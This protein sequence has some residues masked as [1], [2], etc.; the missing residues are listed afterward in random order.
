MLTPPDLSPDVIA[1]Y[2]RDAY[3]VD[4]TQVTFLPIGAD[5][6]AAVYRLDAHG[7]AAYFLKL[8]RARFDE[9]AVAVPAFLHEHGAPAVM[10]PLLTA[11]GALWTS[12]H[13][14]AW[15]LYPFFDGPNGFL[16]PLSD[17]QWLTLG[18]SLR[19]VHS[20]ELPTSLAARIPREAYSP[21]WRDIVAAFSEQVEDG[22]FDD[23]I[24]ERLAAGWR[25]KRWE[26][27]TLVERAADLAQELQRRSLPFVLCHTDLHAGNVLLGAD[28][29]LAIVDWDDPI[30]APKE[31]DL[32]FF[33]AGVGA[34]WDTPREE[35]LFYQGYGPVEIDLTALAYYR[36]ERIVADFASY[37]EQIFEAQGSVEDR[38]N[39]VR[40]VMGQ[41]EP[42]RV[43][44]IAH[45]T[46]QRLP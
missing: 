5:A 30:L 1:A 13:G 35:T 36:Y 14:F 42:G 28:G 17:E 22:Y 19:A 45:R 3:S 37:G 44:D 26:I 43:I 2:V 24:A 7:G 18:K 16:R 38:E 39:G 40:K 4:V 23:P 20:A 29:E 9:I 41:F 11:G 25:E 32:M 27:A 46:Y 15:I 10:A 33:G 6:D 8:R 12:G 34:I 21:H 31:R